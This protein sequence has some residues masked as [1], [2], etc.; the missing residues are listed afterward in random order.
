M[1]TAVCVLVGNVSIHILYD[2]GQKKRGY[3]IIRDTDSY[4]I[5]L[6][7]TL[8]SVLLPGFQSFNKENTQIVQ[9]KKNIALMVSNNDGNQKYN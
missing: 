3:V 4:K 9:R 8:G 1:F 2:W 7:V 6:V 5:L